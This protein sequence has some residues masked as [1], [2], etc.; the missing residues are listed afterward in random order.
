MMNDYT[1]LSNRA[2]YIEDDH[3]EALKLT[4]EQ[5]KEFGIKMGK[6]GPGIL[7]VLL[8]LTG[9]VAINADRMAHVIPRVS[10]VIRTVKKNLGDD[11]EE[12]E[13]MAV[14]DSRE[15]ADAKSEFLAARER[16]TLAEATYKREKQLWDK[17]ITSG[18]AYLGAKQALAE[19]NIAIRSAEQKLHALG[20]TDEEVKGLPEESDERIT[21]YEIR[22][23][24]K[25]TVIEKHITLGEALKDDADAFLVADLSTVW[26]D[27]SI[28]QKDLALVRK[29][30]IVT[31]AC[32]IAG[33]DAKGEISYVRPVVGEKTRT[34]LARVIIDNSDG[35]WKPG[36]FVTAC[37]TLGQIPANVV[38]P[39][40]ALQTMDGKQIVFIRDEDGFEPREIK[41]G[42]ATET[43]VEVLSGL[44]PGEEY[45]TVGGFLIK[46]ELQKGSFGDGHNH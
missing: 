44:S 20:L 17:K 11:V 5:M 28:Y 23:P 24:F 41:V 13:V 36:L 3:E 39:C 22:A 6:A 7:K 29:G 1:S 38:I 27:L 8:N 26:I 12:R 9:E 45:V 10:G 37:V 42:R 16:L 40:T 19:A 21:R 18:E 31:I 35:D 46:S 15:L 30:Q 32:G 4:P 43:L 2:G 34:A 14:L 33:L 25:G